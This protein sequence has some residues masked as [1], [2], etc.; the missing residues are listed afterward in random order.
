MSGDKA[1]AAALFFRIRV[2]E[3]M[4]TRHSSGYAFTNATCIILRPVLQ[5][6]L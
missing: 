1:T 5:G 2:R 6:V 4:I 3:R